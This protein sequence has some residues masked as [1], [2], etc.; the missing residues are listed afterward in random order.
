MGY[1]STTVNL[2]SCTILFLTIRH[3]Y[4]L[5]QKVA[6]LHSNIRNERQ[7]NTIVT[8]SHV[9]IILGTTI[10]TFLAD[11]VVFAGGSVTGYRVYSSQILFTAI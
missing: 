2:I 8:A 5:T 10:V 3:A 11:N 6:E 9:T 4:K 1:L 7:L